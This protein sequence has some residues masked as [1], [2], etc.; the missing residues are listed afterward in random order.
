MVRTA[1]G[2]IRLA[3]LA[4]LA[5]VFAGLVALGLWQV[6][7]RAWKQALIARVEARLAAAPEAAPG[8]DDWSGIG[9]ADEYR[10]VTVGGVWQHTGETCTQAVT[11]RGPGCWVLTPLVTDAGWTVLVNRGYVDAAHRDPAARADGQVAG[12]VRVAGLL[13]ASEPGGG[14]LRANAPAIGRWTSRDV[15]AIATARGLDA[16]TTAPYFIDA[17]AASAP[18]EWPVAGLTVVTFRDHHLIYAL[19]WFGLALMTAVAFGH[20]LR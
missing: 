17:D 15:A 8:P 1:G 10:R 12:R 11:V 19:T 20:L 7:R 5:L 6:E 3:L 2:R 14:F 13:R 4:A 18:S 16:A 9:R